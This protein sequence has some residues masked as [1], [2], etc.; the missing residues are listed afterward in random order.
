MT[1]STESHSFEGVDYEDDGDKFPTAKWQSDTFR[2]E[3]GKYFDLPHLI[4]YYLYVQFNLG[5]DQLAKN[6]LIRTWDGV[7]WSIDYYD[8]D[9]Q[10]GSDNKSF[11][12]GKYDDNRQTKRDGAYVMQGHNS[13]LWNLIVA[14]CWDMIVE[15][16]VSGWNGGASFMSA[17]SIQKAIDHFDT[18]QMKKWCS[19]LYN[20]SGIFKY[21]YP[22][23]NEM[24]VGA[25]GAKQTYPQIY[26]LKGSLKHTGTTSSNAGTT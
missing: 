21:I 22:F 5:V 14:N 10:L 23:L 4:A 15:I 8:G 24:P 16:M 1:Y 18:E 20:K 2:K 11:L 3:A 12:T 7:K 26:G 25:D 17:F 19:R 13:W 6:M 9:C